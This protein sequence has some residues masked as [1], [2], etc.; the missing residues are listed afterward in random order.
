M[1]TKTDIQSHT[2][3]TTYDK[4]V[5]LYRKG[6][7]MNVEIMETEFGNEIY[8]S[9]RGSK[10]R[11][12]AVDLDIS[13][14]TGD[15]L[16]DYC[17]CPAHE[18]Y[19]G[20]C[21]HCVA[22]LLEVEERQSRSRAKA[23]A[24][25]DKKEVCKFPQTTPVLSQL[26][27]FQSM[28]KA[29]PYTAGEAY[30]KIGLEAELTFGYEEF[31]VG[32]KIG[33]GH[34]YVLKDVFSFAERM[35]KGE[36]YAY[37]KKLEFVHIMEAFQEEAKPL[38]NFICNWANAHRKEYQEQVYTY[39]YGYQTRM[40]T[41]RNISL[42]SYEIE[43]LF[44]VLSSQKIIVKEDNGIIRKYD[45]TEE[46]FTADLYLRGAEDGIELELESF[47]YIN[48]NLYEFYTKKDKMYKI[49]KT[50]M[51]GVRD[52]IFCMWKNCDKAYIQKEDIPVFCREVLPELEKVFHCVK[53]N[54]NVADYGIEDV[55]FEIYLDAPQKDFI[56][57]KV[58][59]VY[60]E[61]KFNVY[62][63]TQELGMRDMAEEVKVGKMVSFYCNAYDE[64]EK[65]M[66]L[67][68]DE[69]KMYNLLTEGISTLQEKAEVFV[70]DAL[71]RVNVSNSPKV[72]VGV[73]LS[74]NLL[75][76][77]LT[78]EEMSK[79]QLIEILSAYKKKKKFYRL[80]NGDFVNV[81]E[82]SMKV[83]AELQKGLNITD[84]Q[85]KQEKISVPKYCALYLDAELKEQQGIP[86][87]KNK[88]FRALVRN[89]K[90]VEDNDFE[91]P[92]SL[93]ET[94]REY[95]K[96]GFLWLKTLKNNG[97]CGIL[98]DDMGLGKTL[99]VITFLQSE[100][101]EEGENK[102]CLIVSPASLVFN[103]QSEIER[104]APKLSV[105]VAAGSVA[106]RKE[107]LE[108]LEDRDIVVT[109]YDLLKRD[110]DLYKDIV[111][112]YQVI[113]EAQY[114]K[115]HNT[116]AARAVKMIQ[117][118]YKL[119][120][121][122]TPVENSLSELW[123]IFDYLMPGFLYSYKRFREEIEIPI[124][125]ND[126][127]AVMTRLQK[128]I[129]PF[130][131]RRMKKEVLKDLPDKIEKN[132]YAKM[133]G[134]QQKIYDANVKRLQLLLDKQ[135]DE[136]FKNSKIQILSELTRLR[137]IC[138]N[139][140]LVFEDYK[141]N[142][143]KTDMC[144][145]LLKNAIEGGHKILLF[146]QFTSMLEALEKR[147]D[148]EKISY[149]TLTGSTSKEKRRKLVEQFNQDDTSVFCISLKAGGTGLN[150]TSADIVIHYDPWWNLAV[151]NQATDRAH[152]IGQKSVVTVYKLL[153]KG[154]IEENIV[155]LQDRKRELA[156]QILNGEGMEQGSFSKEEL[157]ELLNG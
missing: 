82:E 91:V 40:R 104:F 57:C 87:T 138:C 139:P 89:M 34:M 55:S 51:D 26:L 103:W 157:L 10:G 79:E 94:L 106:E 141:G 62:D 125:Q 17:T 129:R 111:F 100:M 155:K 41:A 112:D 86:I 6:H 145:D 74:G 144:I 126:Q 24:K 5:E 48:G 114:I 53:E 12:Y 47:G 50:K 133:E 119:A 76:L 21:K 54:F 75:E 118:G 132:M 124:V 68:E 28:K 14:K 135:S 110:I 98:A 37:G 30:G 45:I 67:A 61:K 116:Q 35:A 3:K 99:Q 49:L 105:K 71:K 72:S 78:S 149:Y 69:E 59:A 127:E 1:L 18:S 115:N 7:V 142:S 122:G 107:L 85:L 56:T 136:E 27:Q 143:S 32:F 128:M 113:D 154:T 134:E 31:L 65:M 117:A 146:S 121:T 64:Q 39:G 147:M 2:N 131:L 96:T 83:L 46:T 151:Q 25:K 77:K 43:E 52:F 101:E 22:V 66:V 148:E 11:I 13:K 33:Y 108:G 20:L 16:Y 95:Q 102:K 58:M 97:F 19:D 42:N 153:A 93:A 92:E 63:T 70:S 88:D 81:D 109:S 156:D 44:R 120:L 8:S 23:G 84:K 38:V 15:I 90:T 137:Q 36:N 130:V 9:V 152:R 150:L 29:L 123:S 4:G 73:S 80:K 140:S 60:G